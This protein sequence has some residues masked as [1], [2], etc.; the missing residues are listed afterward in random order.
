MSSLNAALAGVR[1]QIQS[2]RSSTT[3]EVAEPVKAKKAKAALVESYAD[4]DEDDDRNPNPSI[5]E[6]APILVFCRIRPSRGAGVSKEVL[7]VDADERRVE[8][9]IPR[10]VDPGA[11]SGQPNNTKE[12][13]KF[14]F[15]RQHDM[16][17]DELLLLAI[18]SACGWLCVSQLVPSSC[19]LLF[20]CGSERPLRSKHHPGADL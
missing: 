20:R 12:S 1:D 2:S 16:K 5:D 8:F 11:P 19:L 7:A 4:S 13:F 17:G 6:N 9:K 15:V 3:E 18:S 14:N 10:A